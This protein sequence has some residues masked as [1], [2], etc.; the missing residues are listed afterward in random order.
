MVQLR[1]EEAKKQLNKVAQTNGK[2]FA[3]DDYDALVA[4]LSAKKEKTARKTGSGF[5]DLLKSPKLRRTSLNIFFNWFVNSG[6][7]YG[8]SL[9]SPD[10]IAGGNPYINF[11]LSAAVEIP[12]YFINLNLLNRVGRRLSLA[13]FLLF[14]GLV[15]LAIY[16]V[17]E[18]YVSLHLY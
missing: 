1:Y 9:G 3:N 5:F 12:A 10:L 4:N 13:G 17:P 8:L 7:Y 2:E 6:T 18:K 11:F 16:F 14:G 15:L